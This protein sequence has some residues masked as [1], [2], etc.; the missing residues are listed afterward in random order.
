MES[1]TERD[2]YLITE[3]WRLKKSDLNGETCNFKVGSNIKIVVNEA[4]F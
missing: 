3:M 2:T 1:F 4:G